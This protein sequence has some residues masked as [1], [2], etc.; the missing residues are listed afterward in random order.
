M[1]ANIENISEQSNLDTSNLTVLSYNFEISVL[2][3]CGR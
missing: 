3:K 1:K 2:T